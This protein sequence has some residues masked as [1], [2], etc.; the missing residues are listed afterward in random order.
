M[1]PESQESVAPKLRTGLTTGT[2]AT[3]SVVAAALRLLSND[4][5]QHVSV[6]LPKGKVVRLPLHSVK[7]SERNKARASVIKDAGDDPDVTHGAEVFAEV[8]LIEEG[9]RFSALAGVGVVTLP[10]LPIAAGEPAINPVP[11]KMIEQHLSD[12]AHQQGYSGGFSVGIGIK[13]GDEL[14]L[15]TM[16]PKLGIQGGLSILGTTGIVRPFSCSAW[17]ASI[18]QGIDVAIANGQQHLY[19]CTGNQSEAWATTHRQ[20]KSIALIEMGDFAGAVL[21]HLVK[22]PVPALSLVG[23]IAKFTKLAQ[24]AT[25]LHSKASRVD[26]VALSELLNEIGASD[27]LVVACREANTVSEVVSLSETEQLPFAQTVCERALQVVQNNLGRSAA[28]I[29]VEL[30]AINRSG[31]SLA[32]VK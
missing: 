30:V 2:C 25:N 16:N 22:H 8:A 7:L 4:I 27:E 15:K 20:V 26:F 10:G 28:D 31:E 12:I 13:K 6:T 17:I 1:W 29:V 14:A 21:K 18:Y 5:Y 32:V 11:R 3:A 24:G 23:G 9:I 19:A